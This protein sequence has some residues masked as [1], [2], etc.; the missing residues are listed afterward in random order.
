MATTL[1]L[2]RMVSG[3]GDTT[4]PGALS[5]DTDRVLSLTRDTA[6]QD[7]LGASTV[8]GPTAGVQIGGQR[9]SWWSNPLNAV[10]IAGSITVNV[11]MEESDMSANVGAQCTIEWYDGSGATLKG[12]VLNTE[13]GTELPVTTRAA[14]NWAATPTSSAL[15]A[16]DRLRVRIWGNDVGTMG[17]GFTFTLQTGAASGGADGDSYVTFTETITEFV[18]AAVRGPSPRTVS[19]AI[20]RSAVW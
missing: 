14:Q 3:G 17:S 2:F 6:A 4:P 7:A 12:T 8:A 19:Q 16:G 20:Q 13:K 11:W 1:Y 10:T 9:Q 15:A 18:P 5:T